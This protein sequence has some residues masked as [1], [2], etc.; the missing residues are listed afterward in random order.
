V[1]LLILNERDPEHPR[2]GGAETHVH[3]IF[4]RLAA[5]GHQVTT[6]CSAF[7][8]GA[9]RAELDGVHFER[10]GALPWHYPLAAAACARATRRGEADAV[11]DCLNKLP[12]LSPLYSRVPVLGLCHHLFGA[13]A[14][15]QVSAPVAAAVWSAERAIPWVFRHSRFVAIS[16]STRDDLVRRGVS[17]EEI[18]VQH[19]GIRRPE[20]PARPIA[21][22]EPLLVYVGRL[23]A[24]KRVDWLLEVLARVAP[25]QPEV[26]LVVIGRG[27]EAPRLERRARELGVAERVQFA[28]FV[29]DAERDVW[30]ARARVCV[31]ASTKEGFGLTVIEANAV[32]TP[33]VATR[34]PGLRDTVRHGETG[35][36]VEA[37][38]L[39]GFAQRVEDLL[40]DDALAER[41]SRASLEWS[42]RFDW[43]RAADAMQR[44]LESVVRSGAATS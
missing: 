14:F 16:E 39:E 17:A 27:R 21:Q 6:L 34:A 44:T 1:R 32:G 4:S 3:E 41:T 15:R 30:L 38:D 13:T 2:A 20:A 43:K 9:P 37:R 28:G 42:H 12:Y 22:R 10:R 23:E 18:E 40:R 8:G 7:P 31:C 36:L 35:F 26:R 5:R 19:P 29:S 25:R 24:Y 11:V 33:N